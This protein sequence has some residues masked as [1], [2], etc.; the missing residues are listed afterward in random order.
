MIITGK[1]YDI[2]YREYLSEVAEGEIIELV[3]SEGLY[4][5][6]IYVISGTAYLTDAMPS[7]R[8]FE[9]LTTT[10]TDK[11]FERTL[12]SQGLSLKVSG[13]FTGHVHIV[14]IT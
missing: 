4:L 2:V 3:P 1:N 12:Y 7:S 10:D 9:M 14:K 13:E 8:L 5:V 11:G 6:T